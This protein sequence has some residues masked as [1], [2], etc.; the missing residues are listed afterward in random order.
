VPASR[1]RPSPSLAAR[2]LWPKCGICNA[3]GATPGAD[4]RAGGGWALSSGAMAD[5]KDAVREALEAIRRELVEL[6]HRIHAHPELGWQEERSSAWTAEALAAGGLDVEV[7]D[8][9]P[10]AFVAR[11]GS[12]PLHVGI[13][14][15]Y[16]AL[17]SVG[18]A[19]GHNVIAAAAVGAGRAL[20]HVADEVGVTVSVYG[21][22]A[23]EGGGGKIAMLE[24]GLFDGVHAAMMVHP[25][26]FDDPAPGMIAAGHVRVSYRGKEAHAAATPELGVNAA[27]AVTVAQVALGLLRQHVRKTDLFHGIVTKGGEAANIVPARAQ[28]EYHFR[29]RTIDE[30]EELLPRLVRCFEAGAV[31]TGATLSLERDVTYA[32]LRSDPEIAAIYRRNAEAIGRTFPPREFLEGRFGASTDFGNVSR[33]LPAIHPLVGIEADG[34]VNHQPEFAAACVTP[35]ADRAVIDGAL[36]MAWTAVDAAGDARVLDRLLGRA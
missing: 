20:A 33:A 30:L 23:E 36:A 10:T 25:A 27:D 4:L 8:G 29:S 34:A 14:A 22:P 3:G 1:R 9:M 18:H 15:E 26:P 17:P 13:C 19:C 16:D 11:A 35:S 2:T 28:A 32:E 7:L 21:T 6:S 5:P 12:G 31:A 24:R